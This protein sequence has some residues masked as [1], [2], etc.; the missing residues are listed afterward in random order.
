MLQQ[1]GVPGEI[2]NNSCELSSWRVSFGHPPIIF[3]ASQRKTELCNG[4][5]VHG[6]AAAGQGR[7][8]TQERAKGAEVEVGIRLMH[9]MLH[10]LATVTSC[11][12]REVYISEMLGEVQMTSIC[13]SHH[14]VMYVT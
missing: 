5:R 7:F 3:I 13:R 1:L 4:R 6:H 8:S 11:S 2:F 12:C 14:D 10:S 9:F